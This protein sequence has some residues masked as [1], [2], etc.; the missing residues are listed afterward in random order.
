MPPLTDAARR[1]IRAAQVGLLV[2]AALAVAKLLAG[3]IGHS[4][5][6]VADA[7]ESAFDVFGSL[8]VWGGLAV[9][10]RPADEEHPYGHG[11][12]EPLAAAMVALM[13][14]GAAVGISI[15]AAREIRTPHHAPAAWTLGVLVAIIITKEVLFR[16]VAHI[17]AELGS[18]AVQTD[19]WH[20]RSD[21][22][23]SGAAFV[24]I[25]IGVIGGERWA[26][27]DDWAAL[28]AAGV[29]FFNG[30]RLLR[31]AIN[32]LMDRTAAG[33]VTLAIERAALATD[34]VC[35]VEKLMARKSGLGYFV[36]LHV[37]ADPDLPLRDAHVLSG[38]VKGAILAAVPGVAGVLIHMEPYEGVGSA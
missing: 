21:A 20:H 37:Q 22:I 15:T 4:Y 17:G 29:I 38:K 27:A 34:G 2:N 30:A 9:A 10:E 7:A 19:A 14:M 26:S 5:A 3:L 35:T 24:G 11:K 28:V 16:R 33:D 25:A 18:G 23:T 6:L 13:L 8:V 36:D 1:G 31:P 12:A 32:D